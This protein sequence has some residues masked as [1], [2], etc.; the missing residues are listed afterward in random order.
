MDIIQF[1][2]VSKSY[3]RKLVLDNVSFSVPSGSVFALLGDNGAGK[4]TSIK[5]MLGLIHPDSGSARVL[6]LSSLKQDL[7]IRQRVGFVAE[8]PQ[9]Y[10][11]MTVDEIGWFAAG[12]YPG[13]F[14]DSYVR[15]VESHSISRTQKIRELSKGM[16]AK[17][18]L[19]LALAHDPE[20]LILDEPTSGLDPMVRRDFLES[21]VDRAASGKTVF[22]SSHQIG[23]VERVADHV[24]L[25]RAGKLLLVEPL[26]E[27]KRKTLQ[28]SLTVRDSGVPLPRFNGQLIASH[29]QGRQWSALVTDLSDAQI[30]AVRANEFID[31]CEIQH[32]SLEEILLGYLGKHRNIEAPQ[33]PETE[34]KS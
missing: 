18:A 28:L 9:L 7:E 14:F 24:A 19:S 8:Q 1:E 30:S 34:V 26:Q 21:M 6:G 25:M 15:L 22:L 3:R 33:T 16:R 4:T 13:G 5:T 17:V 27:L 11:W 10:D 31:Q 20:L 2:S 12:F 23:E 32:P 29:L